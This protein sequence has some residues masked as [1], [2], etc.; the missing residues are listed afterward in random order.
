EEIS[1]DHAL[2]LAAVVSVLAPLGDLAESMFKRSMGI[3]DMGAILPGHGGI[4][5]RI[6]ALL[7]VVPGAWVLF[8]VQGLAG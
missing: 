3:K 1:L 2:A 7:F 5:D 6:D 4:L 8:T